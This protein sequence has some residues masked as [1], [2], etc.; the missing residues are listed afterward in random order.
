MIYL[1][2]Q[3]TFSCRVSH[4][5]WPISYYWNF[6]AFSWRYGI[7][8]FQSFFFFLLYLL[9][10]AISISIDSSNIY[11]LWTTRY[12]FSAQIFKSSSRTI[13]LS[14]SRTSLLV[15]LIIP[16]IF[17][18]FN[19]WSFVFIL[20]FSPDGASLCAFFFLDNL[21]CCKTHCSPI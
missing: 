19:I 15:L 4:V 20:N 14:L 6:A 5:V 11:I 12:M 1:D 18:I 16:T 10:L 9:F 7:Y 3:F 17:M 8:R 21:T 13:F 2:S